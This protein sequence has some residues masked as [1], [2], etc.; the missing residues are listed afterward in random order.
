[1]KK[2]LLICTLLVSVAFTFGLKA[3]RG[4]RS[5][6]SENGT[7]SD[8]AN[9]IV[10]GLGSKATDR[11]ASLD[12]LWIDFQNEFF[13][14][15]V[16]SPTG[17]LRPLILNYLK[18]FSNRKGSQKTYDFCLKLRTMPL[19]IEL[20]RREEVASYLASSDFMDDM[21]L[22]LVGAADDTNFLERVVNDLGGGIGEQD[23]MARYFF[24]GQ[25]FAALPAERRRE[26]IVDFRR[27]FPQSVGWSKVFEQPEVAVE[28]LGEQFLVDQV[29]RQLSEG[30]LAGP[31]SKVLVSAWGAFWTEAIDVS[32]PDVIPSPE[33]WSATNLTFKI[34]SYPAALERIG[35]SDEVLAECL[36]RWDEPYLREIA[37]NISRRRYNTDPAGFAESLEET[38]GQVKLEFLAELEAE[39]KKVE[40][41]LNEQ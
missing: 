1:M 26:L 12:R 31:Q 38:E 5:A 3:F 19:P 23:R 17:D 40:S 24:G 16:A 13:R 30:G 25:G 4:A 8:D 39:R 41:Y 14:R 27:R 36:A 18:E 33:V 28:S 29:N 20:A 22:R 9:S 15:L 34:N 10:S 2:S 11:S 32:E 6:S 37:L 7:R 35:R 21:L